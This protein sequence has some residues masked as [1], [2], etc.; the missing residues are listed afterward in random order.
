MTHR[1]I[2]VAATKQHVGKTTVSLAVTSGLLKRFSK[3]GVGFIKPVGQQ[4]VPVKTSQSAETI[5]VDK[6]VCLVKEHFK[7]D[8]LDYEYMSPVIIPRGYTK[9]YID[10]KIEHEL[11]VQRIQNAYEHLSVNTDIML[12]EGTGHVAVGSVVNLN[13][14]Q[15]AAMLNADM[16][17]VANGGLGSA[18][19]ELELNRM[20]C[21]AHGVRIAG[22]VINKVLPEKYDQTKHYM[23][24]ALR[25]Y[26]DV[27]LLGCVPDRP[28]LGCPALA[29]LER[30]FKCQLL[31]GSQYR[32]RHYSVQDT[33]LVT[34]S[35]HKFLEN[36]RKKPTRTLYFCHC[37]RHDIILG[38][39]GEYQRRLRETKE[40][41]M[42]AA[43]IVCGRKQKYEL[44]NEIREMINII[45][46]P[47]LHVELSTHEAIEKV[48]NFTPK[49]NIDDAHRAS[50]A[51]EHY[52]PYIDFDTLLER[53]SSG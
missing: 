44:D 38:F 29:D 9:D 33:N 45:D 50:K 46:A 26:W 2:F 14:A 3:S 1:A 48:H 37:T 23:T 36:L 4:H 11:Q 52:E 31:S 30:L 40:G 41:R 17:L 24:K 15:V 10:G 27:P 22:V 51:I 28:F 7:L 39:F 47:V 49:L 8:H 34:T 5:R 32:M 13:N 20:H 21:Q 12:C 42:E 25:Q 53:T 6:D 19:D 18:F 35:L 43:L 16:V